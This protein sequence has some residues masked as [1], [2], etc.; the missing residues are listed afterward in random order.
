MNFFAV[1]KARFS[2]LALREQRLVSLALILVLL[3]L[4]WWLALSPALGSLRAA[5]AQHAKLDAQL[6]QMQSMRSQVQTMQ[7]QPPMAIEEARRQLEAAVKQ[8]LPA[9]NLIFT[10]ERASLTV[11]AAGADA[12]AQF[13][14]QARANA[15]VL[16]LEVHWVKNNSVPA[17][18]DGT[19]ILALPTPTKP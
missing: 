9:A 11:K 1:L 4:V 7:A 5:P 2:A 10:G 15:R 13:L 19:L 17:S 14:A 8:R 3:A 12:L 16:P 18:W 6:Q